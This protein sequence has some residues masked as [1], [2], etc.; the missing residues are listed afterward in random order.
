MEFL[1]AGKLFFGHGDHDFAAQLVGQVVFLA[2]FDHE[3]RALDGHLGLEAAWLVVQAGVDDAAVVAGLVGGDLGLFLQNDELE[4]RAALH[5]LHGRGQANDSGADDGYVE[6][7]VSHND[8]L[9]AGT[10]LVA[11]VSVPLYGD[12]ADTYVDYTTDW[13]GA[14]D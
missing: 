14:I 1:Q 7:G 6:F 11:F 4:V 10:V 9:P 13:A 5:Q 3:T 8:S 12:L 2:E